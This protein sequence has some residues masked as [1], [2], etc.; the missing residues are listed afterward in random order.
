MARAD[1]K[2]IPALTFSEQYNSNVFAATSGSGREDFISTLVP[3]LRAEYRGRAIE[4]DLTGQLALSSF[5]KNHSLNYAAATGGL[6]VNL[7]PLVARL[8]KHARLQLSENVLYTPELPAFVSATAGFNPF[9]TG[10]QTQRIRSFSHTASATAGYELTSRIDLTAGYTYSFLNFG[11]RFGTPIGITPIQG[12]LFRTRFQTVTAGP[13]I[14]VSQFDTVQLQYRY[15]KADFNGGESPGFITQGG[16]AG[17]THV[18]SPKVTG[19]ASAGALVFSQTNRVS[20]IGDASMQYKGKNTVTD[21]KFS[22][23]VAPSFSLVAT[24][25]ES[26]LAAVTVTHQLTDLLTASVGI[27]YAYSSGV[28]SGSNLLFEAYG[29]L[30][31]FRYRISRYTSGSFAYDHFKFRQDFSNL[32]SSVVRDQVI[33]TF[34]VEWR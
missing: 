9:A 15:Q 17:Y 32:H 5:A 6:N 19:S 31:N 12:P 2:L 24:A 3:E 11:S 30:L 22:R 27:N 14:K 33:L 8:N 25:L 26:N 23:S 16:T 7:T 18:F 29:A 21:F 10:I 34:R 1:L 20:F 4:A 28:Q 13:Q